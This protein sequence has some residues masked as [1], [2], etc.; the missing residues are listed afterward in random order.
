MAFYKDN[1]LVR[2]GLPSILRSAAAF[3]LSALTLAASSCSKGYVD[4]EPVTPPSRVISPEKRNVLVLYSAGFNSLSTDLDSDVADLASGYLPLKNS[5]ASVV[6]VYSR[7]KSPSG[8]YSDRTPSYLVRL[9]SDAWGNVVRD[10]LKTWPKETLAASV[11]TV[12]DVLSTVNEM[13]PGSRFGMIFSS[14]ATGWL[15]PGYY[16]TGKIEIPAVPSGYGL[17]SLQPVGYTEMP[18]DP[19]MPRVKSVGADNITSRTTYEMDIEE[20]AAAIPMRL[21][22]MIMDACLMGGVEVAY[23]LKDKCSR[24]IFSQAEVLADGL[25]DYSALTGRLLRDGEPDLLGLCEDSFARYAAQ[26][27]TVYKSITLSMIDCTKLQPLAEVC[28]RIFSD[29]RANLIGVQPSEVQGFFRFDKHWFY[30]MEDILVKARVPSSALDEFRN[31]L[32]G[33]VLYKAASE[34][35]INIEIKSFCGLSMYLPADGN[36]VLNDYY[37]GLSWNKASGLVL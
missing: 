8:D 4:P 35:F 10:T 31:A 5:E 27:E 19:S 20:F 28:R 29:Y 33:C 32:D 2:C 25:C 16:S 22:Y 3:V 30:D 34:K 11:E 37:R 7:R 26:T 21:D 12:H 9:S 36:N 23:A 14:H 17:M 13:Y 18:Y 24:L 6:L 1:N 15:P